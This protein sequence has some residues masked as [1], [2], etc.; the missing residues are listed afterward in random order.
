MNWAENLKT[1]IGK[2]VLSNKLK[3]RKR[4]PVVCNINEAMHIGIIYNATEYVSF[5]IIK[6]LVKRLSLNSRKITVLGY[7]HSKKLIDN[8]LYRKGFD[9]FSRN[10]LNWYYKPAS[11][12]AMEFLN[13]PFDLLINLSLED[14][15]PIHY[16]TALSPALFK[17]GRYSPD[18]LYLDLMIDIEKEK[19]T[20]KSLHQDILK[21]ADRQDANDDIE[22]TIERKTET[23]LQL[24]FLINQLLHY[25]SLI[26]K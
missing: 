24:N 1:N 2:G 11:P 18:D 21:D 12:V 22:A 16:I 6:D 9:F 4:D 26:N 14:H 7:V 20:M 8:Y 25:L 23:E 13:E 5:E 3:N 19:Q 10:D 17:A 15:Y